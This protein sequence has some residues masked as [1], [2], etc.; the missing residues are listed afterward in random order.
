[1]KQSAWGSVPLGEVLTPRTERPT[2]EELLSGRVPIVDKISF[3]TGRISLR[4]GGD[5]KTGMILVRGGDLL[6]SGINAAKGAIAIHEPEAGPVAATIH[7]GAYV[8]NPERADRRY[9]WW[10]LRS[11]V[12]RE[13]LLEKVPGGIKT[14]LKAKRLLPLP[15]PL[16]PLHEQRRVMDRV[17][18]LAL[19]TKEANELK[20]GCMVAS[21]ALLA[22]EL[23]R[24]A[25]RLVVA[26]SLR[27][28]LSSPPRNGWSVRCNNLEGG[29]AVLAVGAVTGFS[30]RATQFKR[31]DPI[32]D[33]GQSFWLK[34]GDLL[35]SRSNTAEFV[36]H[37]AIYDGTPAPC[38]YPDLLMRLEVD[39]TR[40]DK[41]FVWYWL[42]SPL[43]RD[44]L[45]ASAKGTS[46]TMQKISQGTVMRLPFPS[47]LSV[48]RQQDIVTQ[49]DSLLAAVS[50]VCDLQVASAEKIRNTLD[51]IVDFAFQNPPNRA[52][53]A[54][55]EATT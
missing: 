41:R 22:S 45:K 34:S 9:L 46:P 16:P 6:V 48:S 40:A 7:Y 14:E 30:Y 5:T 38:I 13:V 17:E 50:T 28:V 47:G 4:P 19:L 25:S 23:N 51:S 18:E 15:V 8:V 21:R 55:A 32:I 1:M 36:G 26:G 11:A 42:Q 35:V 39:T 12:F 49:L 37:A 2:D 20:A 44:F 3:S 43:A 54:Q 10:L 27:D 33:S 52:H 24:L 53:L 29:T 31:T